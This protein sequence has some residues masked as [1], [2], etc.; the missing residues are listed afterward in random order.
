MSK[1]LHQLIEEAQNGLESSLLNVLKRFEPLLMKYARK[2]NY[3]DATQ[4]LT[5]AFL[6]I[7]PMVNVR[8]NKN[9]GQ[10]VNYISKAIYHQYIKLDKQNRLYN[11]T[12]ILH[13]STEDSYYVAFSKI[14]QHKDI[15]LFYAIKNLDV[16]HRRIIYLYFFEGYSIQEIAH[17]LG[18]SR[19]AINKKKN[20]A[21]QLLAHEL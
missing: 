4:D 2:L 14:A 8:E 5:E 9:E 16:Q 12:E 15:D 6:L 17:I 19:Q 13:E 20:T 1:T 11:Y 3:E 10:L 18:M 7:I 21:L